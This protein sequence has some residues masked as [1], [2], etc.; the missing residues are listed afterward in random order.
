MKCAAVILIIS[1]ALLAGCAGRHYP[2]YAW[3][4]KYKPVELGQAQLGPI[5]TGT[6][7]SMPLTPVWGPL[8][9]MFPRATTAT[10]VPVEE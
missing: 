5:E 8:D 6:G 10:A 1:L 3:M 7:K 9:G 4:A 2:E